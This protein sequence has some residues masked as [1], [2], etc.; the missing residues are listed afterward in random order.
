MAKL[1]FDLVN[2]REMTWRQVAEDLGMTMHGARRL[3]CNV[4]RVVPIA[5]DE[6]GVWRLFDFS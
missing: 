6:R 3:L 5:P 4:S 2:G 1:N